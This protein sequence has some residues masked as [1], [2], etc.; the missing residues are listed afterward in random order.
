M[1]T[2][3]IIV[4]IALAWLTWE[5]DYFTIRLPYG[6]APELKSRGIKME[7]NNISLPKLYL[8]PEYC[9]LTLAQ[10]E[11]ATTKYRDSWRYSTPYNTRRPDSY[12]SMTIGN[13]VIT[14]NATLPN[15]H[16]LI[17]DVYK[18]Q[19]DKPRQSSFK[20]CQLPMDAFI[21]TVRI[22]SH[23]E[24]VETTPKH[25]FHRIVEEYT[26]YYNDCLAGKDW[27]KEHEHNL[28]NF[29][30]SIELSV[31][32]GQGLSLNGNFKRGMI[33]EYVKANK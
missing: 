30:P 9:Q 15:L 3:I 26:T 28:D 32:G 11:L 33:K 31:S 10:Q 22:G 8:L 21:K 2:T 6:D 25:G 12:Q 17:A 7:S 4:S 13:Q 19:T 5:T 20:P 24:W 29:E 23:N 18:V 16:E 14:L 1:I 27:L